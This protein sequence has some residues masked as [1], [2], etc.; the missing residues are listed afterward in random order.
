MKRE[1]NEDIGFFVK[2][3]SNHIERERYNQYKNYSL[4]VLP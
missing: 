2:K 3:I 1:K 4:K